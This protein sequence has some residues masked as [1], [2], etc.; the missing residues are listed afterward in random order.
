MKKDKN[1]KKNG[2]KKWNELSN[3]FNLLLIKFKKNSKKSLID[4][5]RLYNKKKLFKKIPQKF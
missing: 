1:Y 4:M 2:L 3:R 5:N